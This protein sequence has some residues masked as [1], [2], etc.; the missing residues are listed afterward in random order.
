MLLD[1][2][3][4]LEQEL[5]NYTRRTSFIKGKKTSA[6][7][8]VGRR[9]YLFSLLPPNSALNQIWKLENRTWLEIFIVDSCGH[10][11][12][13]AALIKKLGTIE[14]LLFNESFVE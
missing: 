9:H 1:I 13:A 3:T 12:D 5:L 11:V 10:Q 8:T 14:A 4:S 7:V 2:L 6:R